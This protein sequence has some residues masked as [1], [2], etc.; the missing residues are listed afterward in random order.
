MT[1]PNSTFG[2]TTFLII[3]LLIAT[4]RLAATGNSITWNFIN[5]P[6][7]GIAG[8]IIRFS[9]T[10]TNDGSRAWQADHYLEVGEPNGNHLNYAALAYT[11]PGATK[12]AQF[13]VQLPDTPGT[14]T[15]RF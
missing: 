3:S 7:A 6:S 5:L 8:Q 10:V 1:G 2:R 13:S 14:Y 15:Y 9:A 4:P 12:A 11:L